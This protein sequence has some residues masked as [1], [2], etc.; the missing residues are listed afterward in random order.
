MNIENEELEWIKVQIES[1]PNIDKKKYRVESSSFY[2]TK[3][4]RDGIRFIYTNSS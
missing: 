4:K 1:N 3:R 2:G